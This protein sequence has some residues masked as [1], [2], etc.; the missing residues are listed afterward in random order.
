MLLYGIYSWGHWENP[1]KIL[2]DIRRLLVFNLQIIGVKFLHGMAV[3]DYHVSLIPKECA[4]EHVIG[5][6]SKYLLAFSQAMVIF[7][8]KK[9]CVFAFTKKK[10]CVFA[11][12]YTFASYIGKMTYF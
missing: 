5:W 1:M 11:F 2:L 10:I 9:I 7:P 3:T 8:K 6:I 4:V 12:I